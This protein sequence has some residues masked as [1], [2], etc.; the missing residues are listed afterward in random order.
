S[1]E[2]KF[3]SMTWAELPELASLVGPLPL[4]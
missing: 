2:S 3:L 1:V 4:Q